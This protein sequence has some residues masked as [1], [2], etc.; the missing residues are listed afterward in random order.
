MTN[1]LEQKVSELLTE[2]DV[3]NKVIAEI[4]G[5]IKALN[6]TLSAKKAL[7]QACKIELRK[8]LVDAEEVS[9][10]V[11]DF[12]DVSLVKG[13]ES[14]VITDA[15]KIPEKYKTYESN[16]KISK[17]DL[18]KVLS[19]GIAIDGAKLER[20]EATVKINFK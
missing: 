15:D 2:V 14:V 6:H 3:S 12:A 4:E 10:K 18:S 5:D 8:L 1:E 11:E 20:A 7:V 17:K 9:Y 16:V 19:K 13:R